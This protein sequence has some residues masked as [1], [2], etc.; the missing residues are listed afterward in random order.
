[1]KALARTA[2]IVLVGAY[3]PSRLTTPTCI[4]LSSR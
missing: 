4:G 2:Q 1:M 3:V